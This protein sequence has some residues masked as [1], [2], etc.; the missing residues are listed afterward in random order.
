MKRIVALDMSNVLYKTFYVTSYSGTKYKTDL[1]NGEA[2]ILNDEKVVNLAYHNS[3]ITLQ[4]YFREYTPDRFVFVFDSV[5]WRENYTK[6]EECYSKQLYKG[7]RR[8]AMAPAQLAEYKLFKQFTYDFE[9][10]IRKCSSITCLS[11]KGL[12]ADDILA[13]ICHMHGINDSGTN[14]KATP[15]KVDDKHE[16]IV[17]SADKDLLQLLRYDNVRLVDPV[18]GKDRTLLQEGYDSVDYFLYLKCMRGDRGDNVMSAY[19][20]Y[21]T[22]KIR[23]AFE[24]PYHHTNLMNMEW[25]DSNER[26]VVVGEVVKENRLLMDL[27]HQP[28]DIQDIM[29]NTIIDGFNETRRYDH[30]TFLQFMGQHQLKNLRNY[31]SS[32]KPMLMSR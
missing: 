27:T 8:Q 22:K 26:T 32:I 17:V 6:S 23:E 9:S 24:D 25:I 28:D 18:N 11:A 2:S 13:G 30:F 15:P 3:F 7:H 16:V 12:E 1:K 31:M 10:L 14:N 21:R 4:K 19:P 5:N 29:W 20:R